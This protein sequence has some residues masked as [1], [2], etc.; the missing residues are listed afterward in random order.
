LDLEV[1]AVLRVGAYQLMHTRVPMHAAVSTTVEIGKE[2]A[3]HRTSGLVNAVMRRVSEADWSTWVSRVAP[4]DR[5][6]RSA[7]EHGY[8]VWI[9]EALLDALGGDVAELDRALASDRPVTHL[10]ARPRAIT[11][12]LLLELAGDGATAGPFSP[13]A[14]H[15]SGG[16][17]GDLRALRDG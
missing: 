10:A 15:M 6:G 5:I 3:G 14:V 16:D 4:A 7:F 2:V 17:P 8:P 9:A 11:R 1:R 12:E 13:Y